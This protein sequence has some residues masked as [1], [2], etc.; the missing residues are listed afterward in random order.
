MADQQVNPL[1]PGQLSAIPASNYDINKDLGRVIDRTQN[2]EAPEAPNLAFGDGPMTL[3]GRSKINPLYSLYIS[4]LRNSPVNPIQQPY[5]TNKAKAE[6]YLVDSYGGYNPYDLN[7]EN[8]YGENQNWFTQMGN[9]VGKLVIK[10]AGQFANSLMDI[11]NTIGAINEG[12]LDKMWNNPTNNWANDLMNWSEKVMPNYETNWERNHPFLNLIPIYGNA[13]NGWGKVFEQLGFTVGAVGGAVV[14]DLA[15]G[16]LTGGVG[17]VPLAAMQINKAVYRLGKLIG[18]GEDA[19]G[20]LKASL[21]SADDIVKGLRGIDRFNYAVRKGLWAQNMITSGFS[22]AAFEAIDTNKTLMKDFRQEFFEKNGTMPTVEDE[23]AMHEYS[24]K[25]SNARFLMNAALLAMTNTIQWGSLLKPFNVTKELLE[26]EAKAGVRIGLKEGSIDVFEAAKTGNRLT[27]IL[28]NVRDFGPVSFTIGSASEGFEEGAQYVIETGVND[29]YKRAYDQRAAT[30]TNNFM[31]SFTLGLSKTLGTQEGWENIVYGLLGGMMYKGGEHLYYQIKGVEPPNYQKQV[32]AVLRGLNSQTLTGIFEN[33][34]GEGVAATSIENDLNQAVKDGDLYKYRNYKHEQFVNF[35]LSALTQNKY[36]T[37][38][39]QLQELKKLG[40]DDFKNMF[41]LTFTDINKQTISEFVDRMVEKASYMKEIHDRVHRTFINPFSF[42]GTGNYKNAE[43][44]AKQDIENEKYVIFEQVKDQLVYNMSVTKDS[45][46]RIK[47]LTDQ[48]TKIDSRVNINN[49]VGLSTDE[50]LNDLKKDYLSRAKTLEEG[51]KIAKDKQAQKELSWLNERIS[52]IDEILNEKDANKQNASYN[53]LINSVLAYDI[54]GLDKRKK[55]NVDP[56]A[57]KDMINIGRDIYLLRKR[58]DYAIDSYAR[59]TTKGGF[60]SLYEKIR[61][62]RIK[63]KEAEI[64][65]TPE[66][67][68]PKNAQQQ[69]AFNQAQANAAQTPT[70]QPQEELGPEGY[71]EETVTPL[72]EEQKKKINEVTVQVADGKYDASPIELALLKYLTIDEL[73]AENPNP[74]LTKYTKVK[75]NDGKNYYKLTSEIDEARAQVAPTAPPPT[76]PITPEQGSR[77]KNPLRVEDFINKVFVTPDLATSFHLATFSGTK[78]AVQKDIS[79]TVKTLDPRR[80]SEYEAQKINGSYTPVTGYPGVYV[81]KSPVD[82][83]IHHQGI[84]IAKLAVPERLL[85]IFN[86]KLVNIDELTPQAYADL[87]GRPAS[88]HAADVELFKENVAFKNYLAILFKNNNNQPITLTPEQFNSIAGVS[89]TYGELD[90][91]TSQDDRAQFPNLRYTTL[92]LTSDTGQPAPSKVIISIPKL[93]MADTETRERGEKFNLIFDKAFYDNNG[94]EAYIRDY[95]AKNAD[96]LHSLNSRY[97][98]LAIQPDGTIRPIALRPAAASKQQLH[99]EFE[100]LRARILNSA[101]TNFKIVDDE[102]NSTGFIYIEGKKIFYKLPNPEAKSYNDQFNQELANKYYITDPNGKV[103]FSL[104]VSPIGAIRLEVYKGSPIE[105]ERYRNTIYLSPDKFSE[106]ITASHINSFDG[107]IDALNKQI[108]Y[109]SKKDPNLAALKIKLSASSFKA[110]IVNDHLATVDEVGPQLTAATTPTVFKNGTMRILPNNQEVASAYKA[111]GGTTKAQETT[112]IIDEITNTPTNLKEELLSIVPTSKIQLRTMIEANPE[113]FLEFVSQQAQNYADNWVKNTVADTSASARR[114]YEEYILPNGMNIVDYAIARYPAPTAKTATENGINELERQR[115]EELAP[116]KDFDKKSYVKTDAYEIQIVQFVGKGFGVTINTPNPASNTGWVR[117][118][119]SDDSFPTREEALEYAET[120]IGTIRSRINKKYNDKI[121][122]LKA[123]DKSDVSNII[124]AIQENQK[125]V[126]GRTPDNQFYIINGEHYARVTNVL[127]STFQGDSSKYENSRI[128]GSTVDGIVRNYFKAGSRVKPH[129][130]SQE[131]F[132]II[133]SALDEIS[134][135]INEKGETFL[136]NNIVL[137]D[138]HSKI[139]GEVDILSVDKNGKFNIYDIKTSQNFAKYTDLKK[140]SYTRQLSAYAFLF[141][142]QYNS[143]INK[144]GVLPFQIGIDEKGYIKTAEKLDGIKINY[145]KNVESILAPSSNASTEMI[146][147]VITEGPFAGLARINTDEEGNT[148]SNLVK[149]ATPSTLQQPVNQEDVKDIEHP[150]VKDALL[151]VGIT[152]KTVDDVTTF[153]DVESNEDLN[154]NTT[155]A[156]LAASLGLKIVPPKTNVKDFDFMLNRNELTSRL[157]DIE[158]A[159]EYIKSILPSFIETKELNLILDNLREAGFEDPEKEIAGAFKDNIIYLN[160]KVSVPGVEYHEAFHAVFDVALTPLQKQYYLQQAEKELPFTTDM[161]IRAAMSQNYK[162]STKN[163]KDRLY[164][165]YIAERFRKWKLRKEKNNP[166]SKFFD[167]IERLFRWLFRNKNE[168]NALFRQIDK[169]AFRYTNIQSANF[170]S[171]INDESGPSEYKFM[172]IPSKPGII[173]VAGKD[174]TIKRSLPSDKS[175]QIIQSV[176]SYY[177]MYRN[178]NEFQNISD[179]NLL[180]QILDDLKLTYS[181]DN[182]LYAGYNEQDRQALEN[183]DEAFV[184]ANQ[185]SRDIIKEGVQKYI[186]AMK[187]IEQFRD[188]EQEEEEQ[189]TGQPQTGYDNRS[190]NVGGFSSLPGLLRQYIGFASYEQMDQYG[191]S[192]L[193]DGVPIVA[194]VDALHVYYGLLRSLANQSDPIKMFQKMIL[195]AEEN[196]QTRHFVEKLIKD[197][198]LDTEAL[199][200]RNEL[201]ATKNHALVELVKKGFNKYRIDYIFTEHDIKKQNVRT[202]HANR[203]N[204]ENVQF[205]KWANSFINYYSEL[206][207]DAQRSIRDDLTTILSRYFDPRRNILYE[208]ATLNEATTNVQNALNQLGI[209]LSRAYIKYSLLSQQ[210][211]KFDAVKDKYAKEGVAIDATHPDNKFISPL[212]YSFVQIMKIASEITL[213]RDFIDQLSGILSSGANPFFKDIKTSV[214]VDKDTNISEEI[215][216]EIDTA[217][218]TRLL[219]IGRGNAFF[220]ESVGESSYTNA[221]NKVVYAHQDG[222]FHVKFS[223]KLRDAN[224]RKQLREKG[225]REETTAYRDAFDADWLKDNRLLNDPKFEAVADNLLFQRIDGMR[226]VETNRL[227]RVITQEFRE[228]KEGVTYGHYSPREFIANLVNSYVSFAKEQK[229]PKGIIVTVPHLIRVLEASKTANM[230]N[231][232]YIKEVYKGGVTQKAID[233]LYTELITEADRIWNVQQS[234]ATLKD[235]IVENYHTGSFADDGFTVTKGYRGLKLTDNFTSLLSP[236]TIEL[237]ETKMRRENDNITKEDEALIRKELTD[238]LNKMVADSVAVLEKEGIV[239]R[240][241]YNAYVNVLLH[242]NIFAGNETLGLGS[243]FLDNIGHIIINDYLNTLSYNQILYGDSAL[244]LKNDGGIDAVKRAK[245][246]NAAIVSM[247]TDLTAPE[248]GITE[249]FTHSSV[250]I[251]KEPSAPNPFKGGKK[252]IDVADAQMYTTVKGLRYTL[253]G[254]G[255]LTPRLARFLDALENRENIHNMTDFKSGK[256]FDG[257]FDRNNGILRWDEMTNSLKLVY[258]DSKSYFKMSVVVLQPDL[259]SYVDSRGVSRARPGWKT[260]DDLRKQMESKGVHFA[261]PQSASKM[262]TIDVAK[263]KDFSDLKGHLYDNTYFGLQTENPSNKLE[264]TTPTQLLQIIDSEQDDDAIVSWYGQDISVKQLKDYYQSYI[265]AKVQN[266]AEIVKNDIYKIEDFNED[267]EKAIKNGN[268]TPRLAN[269]QKRAIEMLE[270]SGAD[271]QTLEFFSLDEQGV[272][273]FNLNL[274][275][276]KTKATQLYLSYFSRGVLSQKNP[277]YTVALMSG[278]DTRTLRRAT[279]IENG[280]V[281]QWEHVRRDA[282]DANVGQVQNERYLN[283]RDEVTQVGQLYLDELQY[284]VPERD[285]N[286]NVIPGRFYSEMMLPPHYKE[287]L[288]LSLTDEIPEV[289][290]RGLGSRIPLQDKHSMMSLKIVDFLPANLGSTGMFPKELIALSGADFDIDKEFIA[291]YDFYITKDK[292]GHPVFNKYGDANTIEDRWE[293]YKLWMSKN[294]RAVKALMTEIA[295]KD[296]D[297]KQFIEHDQ[298]VIKTIDEIIDSNASKALKKKYMDKFIVYAF[299]QLNL[300]TT[301]EEYAERS[302]ERELNN[303]VVNNRL[304]DAWISLLTNSGM[305]EIAATPA[306]LTSMEQIQ[307]QEDLQLRD[308]QGNIL[309]SVFSKKNNYPV[310]SPIGKY[311]GFKNNSTGKDNIGIDVVANLTYSLMNKGKV[312]LIDPNKTGFYIDEQM[313][314]TFAGDRQFDRKART[315]TGHRTNDLLSTLIS[316]AT[317]EA[318]EQLNALY[319]LGQDAVKTVAYL[320]SLKVP[321]DTAII[322]VNQPIIQNYLDLKATRRNTLQTPREER[323]SRSDFK[324]EAIRTTAAQLKEINNGLSRDAYADYDRAPNAP[325][326]TFHLIGVLRQ[327]NFG[328]K[329]FPNLSN[330]T[331]FQEE[332]LNRYIALEDESTFFYKVNSAIVL[333]KGLG[334]SMDQMD[335]VQRTLAELGVYSEWNKD[336]P[337]DVRYLLTGDA[338]L[339]PPANKDAYYHK[340]T[341][342]NIKQ[343][344]ETDLLSRL[345]FMERTEAIKALNDKVV[346]NLKPS[347]Q[348][349][350]DK[351]GDIKDELLAFLQIAAYKQWIAANDRRTSTLRNSLIYDNE[352]NIPTIVEIAR[353]AMKLAPDNDFLRFILPVSTVVKSAKKKSKN[354]INRDLINTIEGK[355]RGNLEPDMI[356]HIM[357]SLTDL[358][359]NPKTS[360]HARAL[361]DY[362]IVKDGLMFKNKS[363]IRMMPTFLFKDISDAT[364]MAAKVIGATS[365]AEL[366][367]ILRE[368]NQQ[369]LIDR[370][371]NIK[372]YFSDEERVQYNTLFK[373]NNYTGARDALYKKIFGYDYEQLYDKFQEI[374]STDVRHQFDLPLV[375]SRNTTTIYAIKADDGN[376]YLHITYLTDTYKKAEPDSKKSLKGKLIGELENA[377]VEVS[378]NT[379]TKEGTATDLELKK[380]IRVLDATGKYSLYKL[381]SLYREGKRYDSPYLTPEGETVPRGASGVY[382]LVDPVGTPNS[383]G[384]ADLGKRPTKIETQRI[385]QNKIDENKPPKPPTPP[386]AAPTPTPTPTPIAPQTGGA[387]IFGGFEQIGP[388]DLGDLSGLDLGIPD[389]ETNDVL[390]DLDRC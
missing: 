339:Y 102:A 248:L 309:G 94:S 173:R 2:V 306:S 55:L 291:R 326:T 308:E 121:D 149:G 171:E 265:S 140:Q 294:V 349:D 161:A 150:T 257:V 387:G 107:L 5:Y 216:E 184:Y 163:P 89:I 221:E 277:G 189:D 180:D 384:V 199:M 276:V 359:Q 385:I 24:Q 376:T 37:R 346:D 311:Y 334:K 270:L 200:Q 195:F 315:F 185:E 355:T 128:A 317:D 27:R 9:R 284:N 38:I 370:E 266:S 341:A 116:Y 214:V 36:E 133:I 217:M 229:T 368:L 56:L 43:Q 337:F 187:Y 45:A 119:L 347:I 220:D 269:F 111:A 172:L 241:Q 205:D 197:T 351:K 201:I 98:T 290:S 198:G 377:G 169:G 83:G 360:Y 259:T 8:W 383:T 156:D 23:K 14:E 148:D 4:T 279:Q 293:E 357:D 375:R 202:Y 3:D 142:T 28:R 253:W 233:I 165:E 239:T 17:E 196:E 48:L 244:S 328:E 333:T 238:S 274:S 374:Y 25:G 147:P 288:N 331:Q 74:D 364:T 130:I 39:E 255:R 362:L 227:G 134:K 70:A 226:S 366:K 314:A 132:D 47:E 204:V 162:G 332:I 122:A 67:Q 160:T 243:N 35:I 350:A 131:A 49:V 114:Q 320:V 245:G 267:L 235:N 312:T 21:K 232:P 97:I 373:N 26:Q 340:L 7:L 182:P 52:Q 186:N 327:V 296:A 231:L 330:L 389:D 105:S 146:S 20:A 178:L 240:N 1:E 282:F 53:D 120:V 388:E 386:P 40:E 321:L 177:E 299:K 181:L 193:R 192:V 345:I 300:P 30:D 170:T 236:S 211:D 32:N 305:T 348:V 12:S 343:M 106:E 246:D 382:V 61:E 251:F 84:E 73:K 65:L 87:T 152:Y 183:S 143:E 224:F 151:S 112:S 117:S 287:M 219:N 325:L 57:V 86:G 135:T 344:Y 390:S 81:A 137:F 29:Y 167:F 218:V 283:S 256:Q 129:D 354:I 310:D 141:K 250:A 323:L 262:M 268:I 104:S 295:S 164:E 208:P 144:L 298:G 46:D 22:E 225:Y 258:K 115:K 237:I 123:S 278:I 78:D 207:D 118:E 313:F 100:N 157:L 352:G 206:S 223:Y 213:T 44:K 191:N 16:A 307:Y 335:T 271:A 80:Q 88:Q 159:R 322:F 91:V 380:F 126:Q 209:Q 54:N 379:S 319:G 297:Y 19:L 125:Q 176:A 103:N 127:G 301:V 281:V 179:N 138:T 11:P 261:A 234:L 124:K 272:P 66:T 90:L 101:E 212:D 363:F 254:L 59:L 92:P 358:Y 371:G 285:A 93:Y 228:Q 303:G 210:A 34:Y 110:N 79:I 215:E 324:D 247:R 72:T 329:N 264:M 369:Q 41:G 289:I 249:K 51:L 85:F 194:T 76:P 168:L 353:D 203:R 260:L 136:A 99:E 82:I 62:E 292:N 50:G 33:K 174:L 302:K 356:A 342:T 304:V 367:N 378:P 361:Y 109:L 275:A 108:E 188:E 68:Q 13:G 77:P 10:A 154:L 69:A 372:P 365:G 75:G 58:N 155:P 286:G 190:E 158:K 139:A 145:D 242:G 63:A 42:R 113:A 230:V 280:R 95:I 15:V 64:A 318:K 381:I 316:S 252:N 175:K 222:T 153:Y 31:K 263:A 338:K 166:F 18:A 60:K 273:Q 71:I 6:R 96:L 336:I